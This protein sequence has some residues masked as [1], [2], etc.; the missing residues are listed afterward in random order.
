[1]KKTLSFVIWAGFFLIVP[2][3]FAAKNEKPPMDFIFQFE[4]FP[5]SLQKIPPLNYPDSNVFPSAWLKNPNGTTSLIYTRPEYPPHANSIVDSPLQLYVA[6]WNGKKWSTAVKLSRL[7]KGDVSSFTYSQTE[8]G[9]LFVWNQSKSSQTSLDPK[10]NWEALYSVFWDGIRFGEIKTL[11]PLSPFSSVSTPTLVKGSGNLIHGL[12]ISS[13][14]SQIDDN[15][16]TWVYATWNGKKWG[17][18]T[19]IKGQGQGRISWTEE[20]Q[21][22]DRQTG[23]FWLQ[24]DDNTSK[25]SRRFYYVSCAKET[26]DS[27]KVSDGKIDFVPQVYQ[28]YK[29]TLFS[30]LQGDSVITWT[31]YD[32][33]D[34]K[35]PTLQRYAVVYHQGT[36]LPFHELSLD[37][38]GDALDF[39]TL[40]YKTQPT[41]DMIVTWEQKGET[42]KQT[43]LYAAVWSGEKWLPTKKLWDEYLG[44]TNRGSGFLLEGPKQEQIAIWLT[45]ESKAS[46][47]KVM[48]STYFQGK[49]TQ[50][51]VLFNPQIVQNNGL[52]PGKGLPNIS[53]SFYRIV[54]MDVIQNSKHTFLV[55][56]VIDQALKIHQVY[57][58]VYG[59]TWSKPLPLMEKNNQVIGK[60]IPFQIQMDK[61]ENGQ[62]VAAWSWVS[63]QSQIPSHLYAHVWRETESLG[64]TK[65]SEN[66]AYSSSHDWKLDKGPQGEPLVVFLENSTREPSEKI[67]WGLS[68][69]ESNSWKTKFFSHE[70]YPLFNELSFIEKTD[71]NQGFVFGTFKDGSFGSLTLTPQ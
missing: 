16:D 68:Q 34:K 51:E 11:I 61:Y 37:S 14:N 35:V 23:L 6:T 55:L 71:S 42:S 7:L 62:T 45:A 57:G 10:K 29:P 58:M 1:M 9:T 69:F 40:Y 27:A 12:W 49:W 30:T 43:S 41:K 54:D 46:T 60:A 63:T 15:G 5:K 48:T 39:T 8:Q 18:T 2:S 24:E 70:F 67:N 65:I 33:S 47:Q 4:K 50:A 19:P 21:N 22:N 59:D 17:K 66:Y 56:G 52:E 53:P 3:L 32:L 13:K 36:W 44:N 20:F 26:C 28:Q 38:V 25:S 64:T 31:Q